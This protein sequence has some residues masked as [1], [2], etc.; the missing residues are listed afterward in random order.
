MSAAVFLDRDGVLN[1]EAG[2]IHD[3]ADLQLV[4]GAAAAVRQLNE[5]GYFCCLVSNQSGPARGYYPVAHVEALHT[6]LCNLLY[7]DAG[8]RL[9]ALYFCPYL[10]PPAGGSNPELACW[11]TWRKPNTGMLVAAAWQHELDLSRSIVIG[12]KA[13]DVDL[14]HN[15]GA[16]GILVRTGYGAQVLGGRYQ[17]ATRPDYIADDL[18]AAVAWILGNRAIAP[19]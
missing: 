17:H 12:D 15:A 10:S 19:L 13:T 16:T 2:Y 9:D 5:R 3:V 8:A 6:R 18:S 14:A 11:S 7:A 1:I 4:P